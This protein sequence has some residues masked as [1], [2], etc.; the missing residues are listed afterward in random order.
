MSKETTCC[1][2]G[3]RIIEKDFDIEVLKR[4]I[5]YLVDLGVDTFICGGAL[6]FD[7]ICAKEVLNA[8]ASYPHKNIQLHIYAPCE[9]QNAKWGRRDSEMYELLLEKADFVDVPATPYY[10]GCMKDRNFKMVDS[11]AFCICYLKNLRSGTG[12]TYRYAKQNGLKIFNLAG[13][14]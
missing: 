11:S 10:T 12:Q 9:N 7:T 14:K 13:K 6:G 8:K 5:M 4:G 2:T 1:F 3:H